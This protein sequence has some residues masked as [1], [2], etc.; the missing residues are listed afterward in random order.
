M[1]RDSN[2]LTR[3]R[4]AVL[5]GTFA[6]HALII[7]WALSLNAFISPA[8]PTVVIQVVM[9]EK[10]AVTRAEEKLSPLQM[11]K[12]KPTLLPVA[13]PK[14]KI[15]AEPPPPQALASE[16]A[17]ES[18]VSMVASNGAPSIPFNGSGAASN[19]EGDDFI[20]SHRVQPIYSDAS[21]RAREQGYVVVGLLIDEHGR[22]RNTQVVQSSGFHRLDQSAVDALRQW[23]FRRADGKS[24]GRAWTT[25]RYGFHLA[26]SSALDLSAMSLALLPYDPALAEQIRSA[27]IPTDATKTPNPR[28]AAALRRL[29]TAIQT[30]APSVGRDLGPQAPIQLIIK[31]GAVQ[32]IQFLAFEKH[33][34][35]VNAI[36]KAAR[37]NF[38]S[39]ATRWELYKVTQE[40]GTSEW[41]IEV[42]PNGVIN[43]AQGMIGAVDTITR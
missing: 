27:A 19:G 32:A 10:P 2:R 8:T 23:T 29:I 39:P 20:V 38:S 36:D 24:S 41:L 30:A 5:A 34:L 3:T 22:A 18:N 25:F 6:L 26:T 43:T 11:T 4:A 28:G 15:P 31:L 13:T 16:E 9:V 33:G 1:D 37:T 42:A 17:A 21:A 14:L 7:I 35:D 40:L 12:L